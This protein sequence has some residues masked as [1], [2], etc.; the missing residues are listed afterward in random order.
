MPAIGVVAFPNGKK[1]VYSDMNDEPFYFGGASV[2]K[3]PD[4]LRDF[5]RGHIN[6]C[7]LRLS[8][9]ERFDAGTITGGGLIKR[10]QAQIRSLATNDPS[11]GYNRQ[12]CSRRC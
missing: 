12:P 11:V 1:Y 2:R 6:E 3:N 5:P 4:F 8:V 7:T 9:L 10:K